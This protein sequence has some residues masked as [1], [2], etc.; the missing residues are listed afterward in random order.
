[1]HFFADDGRAA[2]PAA[3]QAQNAA[4]EWLGIL[5]WV[6]VPTLQLDHAWIVHNPSESWIVFIVCMFLDH[7]AL[8]RY[9]HYC[10]DLYTPI[11]AIGP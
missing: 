7:A 9:D 8:A 1:M 5:V 3:Q 2:L 10:V 6:E 4:V 11:H